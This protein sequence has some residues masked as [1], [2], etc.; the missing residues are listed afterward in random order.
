MSMAERAATRV[1]A[2][3]AHRGALDEKTAVGHRLAKRPVDLAAL[4]HLVA[5][6][7]LLGELLDGR[8]SPRVCR[9][10]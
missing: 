10:S 6:R 7:E 5:G 8:G 3:E 9:M 1:L 4:E 2:G